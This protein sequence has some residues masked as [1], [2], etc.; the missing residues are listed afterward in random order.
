[1]SLP[2]SF[3]KFLKVRR[4]LVILFLA[5]LL[6]FLGGSLIL[7]LWSSASS[8]ICIWDSAEC[9]QIGPFVLSDF[10]SAFSFYKVQSSKL[11]FEDRHPSLDFEI[12]R[13]ITA[14]F[15]VAEGHIPGTACLLLFDINYRD[16]SCF[17]VDSFRIS[18]RENDLSGLWQRGLEPIGF[19]GNNVF[20]SNLGVSDGELVLKFGIVGAG[21]IDEYLYKKF[22]NKRILTVLIA[23]NFGGAADIN[24]ARDMVSTVDARVELFWKQLKKSDSYFINLK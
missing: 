13:G 16:E 3:L 6:F 5:L 23:T 14:G 21:E 2:I 19:G 22:I 17:A 4:N 12:D 18:V 8:K 11:S 15:L 9:S 20:S 24:E 1:M 10:R 7:H